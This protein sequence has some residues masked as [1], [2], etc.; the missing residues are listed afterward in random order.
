[1]VTYQRCLRAIVEAAVKENTR[2][3]QNDDNSERLVKKHAVQC[4]SVKKPPELTYQVMM[5]WDRWN[6]KPLDAISKASSAQR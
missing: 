5:Y 6:D 1:M 2:P 3:I 4:S